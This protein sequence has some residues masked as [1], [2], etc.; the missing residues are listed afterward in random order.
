MTQSPTPPNS[1]RNLPPP[2]PTPA[3]APETTAQRVAQAYPK[4]KRLHP[5]SVLVPAGTQAISLAEARVR[6]TIVVQNTSSGTLYLGDSISV[7]AGSQS[8][9]PGFPIPGGGFIGFEHGEYE[10]PLYGVMN[11]GFVG[12]ADIRIIELIDQGG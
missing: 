10:G 4:A 5:R 2:P 6:G 7:T 9:Q 8:A 11:S 1:V 3:A 12:T